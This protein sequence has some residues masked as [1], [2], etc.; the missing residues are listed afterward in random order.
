MEN[1]NII[2]EFAI[3]TLEVN[4]TNIF[5]CFCDLV[6]RTNVHYFIF[7]TVMYIAAQVLFNRI[8]KK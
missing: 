2:K 5:A 7:M 8:S 3:Y 6:D 4:G 1:K